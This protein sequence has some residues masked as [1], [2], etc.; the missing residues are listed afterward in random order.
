[1]NKNNIKEAIIFIKKYRPGVEAGDTDEAACYHAFCKSFHMK[2]TIRTYSEY[3]SAYRAIY[4]SDLHPDRP[5]KKSET[6]ET[7]LELF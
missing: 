1:M 6:S 2:N 4:G 7:Q 3:R 5:R